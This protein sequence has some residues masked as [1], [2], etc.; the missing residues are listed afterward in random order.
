MHAT[1]PLRLPGT[2][3][4]AFLRGAYLPGGRLHAPEDSLK[5]GIHVP[6]FADPLSCML[7]TCWLWFVPSAKGSSHPQHKQEHEHVM[8]SFRVNYS[9]KQDKSLPFALIQLPSL[10]LEFHALTGVAWECL[11]AVCGARR[12]GDPG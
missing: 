9:L 12:D 4:G 5:Y 3:G 1:L 10:T 6:H 7:L 11:T 8:K 2:S